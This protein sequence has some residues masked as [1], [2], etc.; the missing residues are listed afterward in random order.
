MHVGECTHIYMY[1]YIYIFIYILCRLTGICFYSNPSTTP[2]AAPPWPGWVATGAAERTDESSPTT[3]PKQFRH[4]LVWATP[5]AWDWA[6]PACDPPS[7]CWLAKKKQ[8]RAKEEHKTLKTSKIMAVWFDPSILL[9]VNTPN[10][11]K[12]LPTA[13]THSR[14]TLYKLQTDVFLISGCLE[15]KRRETCCNKEAV[16]GGVFLNFLPCSFVWKKKKNFILQCAACAVPFQ[17]SCWR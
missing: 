10:S 8:G 7:L 16:G 2:C 13:K 12:T 9:A 4:C 1:I 14:T 6:P 15:K 3:S 17:W 5:P 11:Y